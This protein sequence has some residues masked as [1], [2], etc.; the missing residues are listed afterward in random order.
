MKI[1]WQNPMS[2]EEID[3]DLNIL[4]PHKSLQD[5][6]RMVQI[7]VID[8]KDFSPIRN[9]QQ[10]QFNI[11]HLRDITTIDTIRSYHL[12]L[13]DLQG[14][15]RELNPNQQGAHI[16]REI[17]AIYPEK[18]IVA[19]TGGAPPELLVPSV[20]TADKFTQKDTSIEDWCEL[21]DEGARTVI[22]PAVVWRK[23]RHR[24]LDKGV[25]PF[26]L[27]CLE[28]TLVRNLL[29]NPSSLAI[30]M[31]SKSVELNLSSDVR[32]ILSSLIA[33]AVFA[34]VM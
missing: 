4:F 19:Y 5:V 25:T 8:D 22:H 16:I 33:N 27:A 26:Q 20:E 15:G 11:T 9:L 14:I 2:I 23:N 34:L 29:K 30:T 6:R 17:R 13:V 3:S 24:L 32:T 7:A 18:Y 1:L 31:E 12:V 28:D 10:H 21:L